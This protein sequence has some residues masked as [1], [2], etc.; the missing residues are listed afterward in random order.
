MN[1]KRIGQIIKELRISNGLSQKSL[2]ENICSQAQ[3]SKLEV[4]YEVPYSNTLYEISKK[5]GVD[6]NFFFDIIETPQLDL[7]KK[8]LKKIRDCIRKKDY[9]TVYLIVNKYK[10]E[11]LFQNTFTQ[12]FFLWHEAV[13]QYYLT[14]NENEEVIKKLRKAISLTQSKSNKDFYKEREIEI[15]ISIAVIFNECGLFDQATC[16]YLKA[17]KSFNLLHQVKNIRI[18]IRILYD[19]SRN[20]YE[21]SEYGESQKY[22]LQGINICIEQETL[23]LLGEL[24]FIAAI[25]FDK[26]G[27]FHSSCRYIQKSIFI[28]ELTSNVKL[29]STIAEQLGIKNYSQKHLDERRN[30]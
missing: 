16:I 1:E 17:L 2:A 3:I 8:I 12:Q 21:K 22:A 14:P 13:A 9:R 26:N 4:G 5:L 30:V 27:D 10:A 15:L 24:F 19:L 7:V 18:K 29:L 28:F 11:P 20:L 23:Y 25:N 6:M